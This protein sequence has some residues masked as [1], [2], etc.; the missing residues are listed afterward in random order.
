V[1]YRNISLGGTGDERPLDSG[2]LGVDLGS[3][4]DLPKAG[5]SRLARRVPSHQSAE[6]GMAALR[7]AVTR[8]GTN[9]PTGAVL[10]SLDTPSNL[11]ALRNLARNGVPVTLLSSNRSNPTYFSRFASRKLICPDPLDSEAE[12][13]RFL[14]DLGEQQD[15]KPVLFPTTDSE[16]LLYSRHRDDLERLYLVPTPSFDVAD[17]LVNKRKFYQSLARASVPHP[18][19]YFPTDIAD[20]QSLAREIGLPFYIKPAYSR[21]F[22]RQY[23]CKGLPIYSARDLDRAV[24]M[25]HDTDLE[26]IVQEIIPGNEIYTLDTCFGRNGKPLAICGFYKER[27]YPP[28]FGYGTLCRTAWREIPNKIAIDFLESIGYRGLAEPEFKRDPRDDTYKLLEVNARPT[29]QCALP[30]ACGMSMEY[31]FYRDALGQDAGN[32]IHPEDGVIWIDEI[33]DLRACLA[34]LKDRKLG[35]GGILKSFR[36]KRVY[37]WADWRDPLPLLVAFF[38]RLFRALARRV[39]AVQR[40]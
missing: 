26:L 35:I 29:L 5:P 8:T 7:Q 12:F 13:L 40:R 18:R 2:E 24:D 14:L 25:L 34:Q 20:I 9:P 30:A 22:T 19:T 31:L 36:G 21:L 27:Q 28:D 23:K 11:G 33:R 39:F 32:R 38:Q 16:V 15:R 10:T 3:H 17:Q 37:A 6:P 4:F 1:P